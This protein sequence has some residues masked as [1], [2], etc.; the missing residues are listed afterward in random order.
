MQ[1]NDISHF[2]RKLGRKVKEARQLRGM[3]QAKLGEAVGVTYQQIQKYEAGKNRISADRL[4]NIGTA[5]KLPLSYFLDVEDEARSQWLFPADT[6]RLATSIN[7][8]PSDVIRNNIKR[9]VNSINTA[10]CA[11]IET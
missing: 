2:D 5:L 6:L 4:N 7:D 3:T 10:W 1:N 8:L 9:L 11:R